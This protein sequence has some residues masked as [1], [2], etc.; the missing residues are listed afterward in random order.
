MSSLKAYGKLDE[1]EQARLEARRRTRKRITIISL[2]SILLVAIVVAAVVGTHASS[3][4]SKK[5]GADKSL[6]T[7]VKAVCDVT[8][9]KDSCYNSLAP[10][11]KPDQLQPEELFKL[12]IQVAKNEL[13]KASQHF[14]KDGGVL[15]N[16]VKDNMT[17]TALENCQELLS[18]ALDHLDNSLEAGHGVNVIDIVDDLRSWL[19]TSGTCYQTCIDGLSETKLEATAHDYLKNS[20]ELTSNSL[21]I[22]TWISKVAS[23]V[24]IHRRLMNYEDQDMPKWLHPEDRKLLQSSDLKKKA[25]VVVAKDGSGK[26]KRISDALKNVPEKSKKRYVIYVKKG[27]YFENVRVEK[28]QWNVMM[29]GDG[30]KETIVSASLNVV[31]GT[32]T[33]STATFAVFGKGF[34]ARDMGFRNTAG[35]IKHQAVALMSNADMSAFYRCSMDAFQDTLYAHANRQFYREC[36]IYGTVDFIFGNS[37]VV[38]Q[39]SSILPRKPMQGQQNTITAQGKIDPN[40]NT[41]ISIQNCTIW[42]YGDLSSV[43]TFLG[44][45]WKNYSTTVFMRSMMGSLIDPAGWLPWTGNTAPPTIFYSEFENFGPGASTK[46]RVKWKGLKTI[47]NKQASKFTVKAFIQGEEWLTGTGISYKPGL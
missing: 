1:A 34:I 13:S 23:S 46:N 8:L 42:P 25:D 36:N 47:T 9:Y 39:S 15:Y 40:Q 18:L 29:I 6:S 37:A 32:P 14:S 43:K 38:I 19:S 30:M 3:G 45:P 11:A 4:N 2:S 33:F 41:G 21:A 27:I 10:V 22:I 26:Y 16:G 7:S 17:I 31:D 24:N 28:K 12:A 20:S 44:R 5:G 35:A